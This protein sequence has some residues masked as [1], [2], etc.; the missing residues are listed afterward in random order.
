M[1][2][3]LSRKVLLVREGDNT[4]D[5]YFLNA[6]HVP[7]MC[8]GKTIMSMF[9]SHYNVETRKTTTA[10]W[11]MQKKDASGLI[12]MLGRVCYGMQVRTPGGGPCVDMAPRP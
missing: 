7:Y 5:H 4:L 1:P 6:F 12:R 10:G 3:K 9:L 8:W 2:W 11:H